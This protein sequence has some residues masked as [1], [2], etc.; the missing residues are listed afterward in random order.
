ME[1][2][3]ILL[4]TYRPNLVYF[5][6]L[7]ESLNNQTY[8][9]VNVIIR[10][11]SGSDSDFQLVEREL[12]EHLRV[13]YQVYRNTKNIGSNKTFEL[14]TADASADFIAFCDQDDI[15]E[16]RKIEIL[17]EKVKNDQSEFVYSD[18]SVIDKD[19]RVISTSLKEIVG[20][21]N[22]VEGAKCYEYFIRRNS[23]TGC[24]LL[25]KTTLARNC[26][27][28][29]DYHV[30]VHDHWMALYA[31]INGVI[32][33]VKLPLV[34]YRIHGNNQI[35]ASVLAN[36]EEKKDYINIKLKGEIDRIELLKS[37]KLYL[38]NDEIEY[39]MM[40]YE[41]FTET[42]INYLKRFSLI[43]LWRM[44][45]IFNFD[46]KLIC[47]EIILGMTPSKFSS[48]IIQKIKQ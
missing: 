20:R 11:D 22:H 18:L 32:S 15:W 12:S 26:L 38:M 31:S 13:S 3:D 9:Y 17:M 37:R 46:T 29:P 4:A 44:F 30:F 14:L 25:I 2:V 43:R 34:K 36:I 48:Y 41:K 21:L 35:G 33:Y 16:D 1:T 39:Q 42:R 27:P 47:F 6:K 40:R 5:K 45:K 19:D 7:L 23:V 10:D 24:T 8:P 28:F